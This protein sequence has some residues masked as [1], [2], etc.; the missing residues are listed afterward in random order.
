MNTAVEIT[1]LDMIFQEDI[2]IFGGIDDI[3]ILEST[4][5]DSLILLSERAI[6]YELIEF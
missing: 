2:E 4:R 5:S 3:Y 1:G 6:N